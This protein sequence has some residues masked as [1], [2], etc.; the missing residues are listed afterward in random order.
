MEFFT[1]IADQLYTHPIVEYSD[2]DDDDPEKG[3]QF[4]KL[5]ENPIRFDRSW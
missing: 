2:D 1:K 4:W 5:I 3:K